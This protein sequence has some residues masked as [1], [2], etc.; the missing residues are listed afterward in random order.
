MGAYLKFLM[1]ALV[2]LG[3]HSIAT[4]RQN[5][6]AAT[7]EARVV[8]LEKSALA[9]DQQFTEMRYT[10]DENFKQTKDK[11]AAVAQTMQ[12][13]SDRNN[14]YYRWVAAMA[15]WNLIVTVALIILLVRK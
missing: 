9:V 3:K 14:R 12:F 7:L 6:G 10:I 8:E 5:S 4:W 15:L 2:E 1:P 13:L 11:F